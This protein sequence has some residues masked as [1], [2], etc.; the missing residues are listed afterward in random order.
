[1]LE[2]ITHNIIEI[3]ATILGFLFLYLE[4]KENK[5]LW[6][7]GLLTSGLYIYV[8]LDAK[9]YAD[10]SL[11]VYYVI[12]S[13]YGWIMWSRSQNKMQEQEVVKIQ[14]LNRSLG[15][16]L[17]GVTAAIYALI[18]YILVNYTDGSLPYW[19]A[20]TTALGIVA[21]WMLAK[22]IIEQWWV[23]VLADAVSM[24]LYVYK[25]LYPTVGLYA[26]YTILAV[27]GYYQWK[28][29]AEE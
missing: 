5:W 6:F 26:V 7:V 15:L 20:F 8:F 28:R 13:I 2:F 24:C 14:F 17:L 25:G 3:I 4:I 16:K 27:V 12:I 23:W 29:K 1:M 11:Q 22:K 21:T 9:L 18:A 10:M 19:D